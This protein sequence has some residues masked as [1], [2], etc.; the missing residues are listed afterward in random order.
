MGA[1]FL[2]VPLEAGGR[3]GEGRVARLDHQGVRR[4][5]PSAIAVLVPRAE[6]LL[7]DQTVA[8]GVDPGG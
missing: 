2:H 8:T 4:G 5:E 7:I 6:P 1:T 3:P